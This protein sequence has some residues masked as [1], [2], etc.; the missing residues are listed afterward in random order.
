M[1]EGIALVMAIFVLAII[2]LA[3]SEHQKSKSIRELWERRVKRRWWG[4]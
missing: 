4:E 3:Y 1:N 2:G